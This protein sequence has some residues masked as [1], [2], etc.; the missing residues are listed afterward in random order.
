MV[1]DVAEGPRLVEAVV[2]PDF[3][4]GLGLTGGVFV[5]CYAI[6]SFFMSSG[7][8]WLMN[9]DIVKN[10]FRVDPTYGRKPKSKQKMGQKSH[11]AILQE[12]K[13]IIKNR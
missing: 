13:E 4:D 11:H 5:G 10:L 12:A 8:F 1:G 6:C 9:L 3:F 7:I 2:V